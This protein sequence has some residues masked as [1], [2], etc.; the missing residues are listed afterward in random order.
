MC[1]RVDLPA[2]FSPSSACTSPEARV[3]SA[4]RSA[5]T[6]PNRF[7]IP[8]SS[9]R[10]GTVSETS[11]VIVELPVEIEQ[12]SQMRGHRLNAECFGGVVAGVDQIQ[13]PF[14][15]IEV[16]VVRAFA[17]N[18]CVDAGI[19]RLRE[20]V[21]GAAG[22]NAHSRRLFRPSR[23]QR[24]A[25]FQGMKHAVKLESQRFPGGKTAR[26]FSPN[27]H[28]DAA[29]VAEPPFHSYA[30][31]L[32]QYG[33]VPDLRVDIQWYVRRVEWNIVGQQS[34]QATIAPTSDRNVAVPEKSMM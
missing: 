31:P 7:R 4:P 22:D 1:I 13:A 32:S 24:G 2:P 14:H 6:E 15:G 21:S 30:Q 3:K 20:H 19:S 34:G 33:I 8:K 28:E 11:R 18:E 5:S 26:H 17:G 12:L 29:I 16:G 10:G 27:S 25:P 23:N 9:R